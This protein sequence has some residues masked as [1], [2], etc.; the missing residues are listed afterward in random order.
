MPRTRPQFTLHF[1][2]FVQKPAHAYVGVHTFGEFAAV[3]GSAFR[4]H[5]D[6]QITFVSQAEIERRGFGDNGPIDSDFPDHR[7]GTDAAIFFV[8][9]RGHR[10]RASRECAAVCQG[11]RS[12][13]AR[14]QASFHV[15]GAAAVEFSIAH[16]TRARVAHSVDAH[17]IV[18]RVEHERAPAK[19]APEDSY[20]ARPAALRFHYSDVQPDVARRAGY[21]SPDLRLARRARHERRINGV[22]ADQFSPR[23]E[24]VIEIDLDVQT[25]WHGRTTC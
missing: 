24:A 25:R 18:M 4:F 3:R 14:G 6:P 19:F 11:L 21:V 10:D 23:L 12:R 13:H 15:V 9:H 16:R 8:G 5:L 17:G 2:E 7:L 1:V 20:D 22:N